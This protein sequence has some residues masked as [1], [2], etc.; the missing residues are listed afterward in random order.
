VHFIANE[1]KQ[2][3]TSLHGPSEVAEDVRELCAIE[4]YGKGDK[5]MDYIL[6]RNKDIQS[7]DWE[8]CTGA[9]GIRAKTI[10]QC[11]AKE[12]PSL[13]AKD[14]KLAQGL[15]IT[16]SPTWVVNNRY[17]FSGVDAATVQTNLCAHNPRL[18][19]CPRSVAAATTGAPA[20]GTSAK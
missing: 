18:A 17:R 8:R 11:A 7:A 12:G 2:G 9:N 5:F 15:G 13:L 1:G 14:A 6:C 10:A 3:L 16:A 4:A 19:G 20:V